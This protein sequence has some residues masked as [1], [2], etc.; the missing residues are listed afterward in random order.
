MVGNL[1]YT[2]LAFWGMTLLIEMGYVQIVLNVLSV[3]LFL[4]AFFVGAVV[5]AM[6]MTMIA[7]RWMSRI[8]SSW[9]QAV[10]VGCGLMMIGFGLKMGYAL[11][12]VL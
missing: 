11:I 9:A 10:L 7:S 3:I 2:L 8:R 6:M 1:V 12:H 4:F 5:V